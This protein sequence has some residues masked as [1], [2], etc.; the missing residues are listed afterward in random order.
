MFTI[1]IYKINILIRQLI[2]DIFYVYLISH[3]NKYYF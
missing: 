3:K 1:K 2:N